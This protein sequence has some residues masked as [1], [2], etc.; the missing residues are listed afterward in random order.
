MNQTVSAN[1]YLTGNSQAAKPSGFRMAPLPLLRMA[2]LYIALH[3]GFDWLAHYSHHSDTISLWYPTD[4]FILVMI[5]EL[6]LI[7]AALSILAGTLGYYIF[8]PSSIGIV[9]AL[10]QMFLMASLGLLARST[11]K[12]LGLLYARSTPRPQLVLAYTL[13]AVGISF[14]TTLVGVGQLDSADMLGSESFFV[15][16]FKWWLGDLNGIVGTAL[17]IFFSIIPVMSGRVTLTLAGVKKWLPRIIAYGLFAFLPVWVGLLGGGALGLRV[18]FLVALPVAFAALRRGSIETGIAIF[19]ANLAFMFT[20]RLEGTTR[21]LELQI[22]DLLISAG[23][24]IVSA[25]TSY[26]RNMLRA[27]QVTLSERD[28]LMQH[29]LRIEQQLA[30]MRKLEALGALSGGMAHELNN[31]LH[32]IGTFARAAID[33][34]PDDRQRYLQQ[35]RDCVKSASAIVSDVLAFARA[36]HEN[37]RLPEAAHLAGKAIA[38]ATEVAAAAIS[39]TIRVTET[40]KLGNEEIFIAPGRL[41]QIFLNLYRNAAD[42]MSGVAGSESARSGSAQEQAHISVHSQRVSMNGDSARGLDIA[43]GAYVE[44]A[45]ADTGIGMSEDTRAH[46]FEPFFT[47]KAIGRGTGLGLAVVYGILKGWKGGIAVESLEGQGACFKLYIPVVQT[48]V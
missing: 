45:V 27:L 4:G 20:I 42:A 23:G 15:A 37:E 28:A 7:G 10:M 35:I 24:V 43:S 5:W 40:T 30:E 17:F 22:L 29:K 32:P 3:F 21:G 46:A 31:L 19:A 1:F 18:V 6:R 11:L 9:H 14:F 26:Q 33:A 38:D 25:L 8:G 2:L 44:I 47:T 12:R 34:T 13:T 16:F 39:R 48:S 41:I 36:E